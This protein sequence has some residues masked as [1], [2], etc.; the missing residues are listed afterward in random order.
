[1]AEGD[2]QACA[3]RHFWAILLPVAVVEVAVAICF[4]SLLSLVSQNNMKAILGMP[5]SVT[6]FF[7]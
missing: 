6:T 2:F 7:D 1:M 4:R 3:L 5:F